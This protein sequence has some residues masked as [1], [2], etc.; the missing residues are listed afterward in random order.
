[1]E[2]R[3]CQ[4]DM[5]DE[6]CDLPNSEKDDLCTRGQQD[7]CSWWTTVNYFEL[8]CPFEAICV[9]Q[10]C[11]LVCEVSKSTLCRK[12]SK[13]ICNDFEKWYQKELGEDRECQES[14]RNDCTCAATKE[15]KYDRS[16]F[17]YQ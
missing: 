12:K 4:F 11:G 15:D 7:F 14:K 8:P 3:A 1:M 6:F 9:E 13:D 17:N 5:C 16:N 2:V 10:T